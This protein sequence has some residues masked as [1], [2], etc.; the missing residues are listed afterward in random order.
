MVAVT[1]EHLTR[2]KATLAALESDRLPWWNVWREIADYYIPKRYMWLLSPQER[3][4]Y[5]SKNPNIL[6]G[7][8]TMAGRT[9]AA[10]MMN[11]ITSPTRPWFK[12]RLAGRRDDQTSYRARVWLDEVERR[13]LQVLAESNFYNSMA[14]MFLDLSFFGTASVLIY[15]DRE[16][17]IR[18]Y[19][20]ALGEYYLGQSARQM[21]NTFARQFDLKVGQLVEQFGIENVSETVKQKFQLGGANLQHD[22]KV[23]HLIEPVSSKGP[24]IGKSFRAREVFWE[25]GSNEDKLLSLRGYFELPGI[26]P[27]WELTGNDAYGTSPAMDALGDVI[28]LQHETKRKGQGLD[29]MVR[30]PMLWDIQLQHRPTNMLPGGNT[31]VSNLGN[32]AGGK[33]AYEARIPINELTMDIRDVQTRIRE[34]FHNDLFRMIS[35]LETVRS[36]TEIDARREEKL[37]LLGPVLDRNENEALDPALNR[38]FGI[39][40]RSGILP[41]PPPELD[42]EAIQ[43]QYVSILAAA[44]TA[45]GVIPTERFLALIGNVSAIYPGAVNIPNWDDL[46]RDYG[47]DIGV[48][49]KNINSPEQTEAL[50]QQQDDMEGAAQAAQIA[51]PAAQAAKLLSET[52]VGGGASALQQILG[53]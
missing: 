2:F 14:V 9:L 8:G 36:A 11:G 5:L 35:Q 41:D 37:V 30:P 6:D 27:R 4:R 31:F 12:F 18:C 20:C 32:N 53:G 38:I 39:C 52:E 17:V 43:I 51:Q 15:E 40:Q 28:Q 23:A 44:Q 21:V 33:P 48:K 47:R 34:C 24:S 19:N 16:S 50:R 26:W 22:V 25:V 46:I 49:T 45:V 42:G 3:T 7:T 10:G 13:I 29:Y 1:P